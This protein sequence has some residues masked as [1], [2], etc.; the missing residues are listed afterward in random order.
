VLC[1][2]LNKPII[3]I[4]TFWSR[5]PNL[6]AIPIYETK[7]SRE[8]AQPVKYDGLNQIPLNLLHPLPDDAKFMTLSRRLLS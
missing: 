5:R 2:N 7:A 8:T 4:G 6:H 1:L 3:G